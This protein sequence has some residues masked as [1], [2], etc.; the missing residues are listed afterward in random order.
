MQHRPRISIVMQQRLA[1]I[2][3]LGMV[4]ATRWLDAQT[5][6]KDSNTAK[7]SSASKQSIEQD[8]AALQPLQYLVSEWKGVGQPKRGS[9][10]GAWSEQL[11]W[12]GTLPMVMRNCERHLAK[13]N[14][15]ARGN[16]HLLI[17]PSTFN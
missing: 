7:A 10:V 11:A 14:I 3:V 17:K 5:P 9:N 15:S 13:G 8:K 12:P 4:L 1:L 6:A 16:W 2:I